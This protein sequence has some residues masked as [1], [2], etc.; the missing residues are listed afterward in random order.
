[1]DVLAEGADTVIVATGST[2]EKTGYSNFRPDIAKLPGIDQENV[3]SVF[4]VLSGIKPVGKNVVIIDDR[5]DFE[6]PMTAEYLGD[7]GKR[8]AIVTRL[9]YV[10]MKIGQATFDPYMER[11][12]E[13]GVTCTAFTAPIR[14]EDSTV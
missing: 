6:A 11:L 2:P 1:E 10:G 9:P 4:E 13:R 12:T 8:V 3:L 7:Q 5:S 14:I